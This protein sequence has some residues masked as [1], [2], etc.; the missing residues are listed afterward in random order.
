M[1]RKRVNTYITLRPWQNTS[2]KKAQPGCASF[3][4]VLHSEMLWLKPPCVFQ[5]KPCVDEHDRQRRKPWQQTQGPER[6]QDDSKVTCFS[7]LAYMAMKMK[8]CEDGKNDSDY[9]DDADDAY[10]DVDDDD[11]DSWDIIFAG[12]ML[13]LIPV[14]GIVMDGWD[15][16][17]LVW[18]LLCPSNMASYGFCDPGAWLIHP[19]QVT[20]RTLQSLMWLNDMMREMR[21]NK[22]K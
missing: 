7:T 13:I 3:V 1:S 10:D 22:H 18:V 9:G 17:H 12:T 15:W 11:F 6:C 16:S 2:K 4:W 20:T 21:L 14:A 19:S 8:T 5:L